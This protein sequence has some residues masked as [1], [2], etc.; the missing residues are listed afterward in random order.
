MVPIGSRRELL[1]GLARLNTAP[2]REAAGDVLYGPGIRIELTPGQDP[3]TQMLVTINEE[4]I[5]WLVLLRLAK[6]FRWKLVDPA[7][8]RE[9]SSNHE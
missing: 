6:E 5:G 9:L 8:G 1:R 7:T 3:V 2:E 4:E